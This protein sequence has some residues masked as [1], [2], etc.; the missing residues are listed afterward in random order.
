MTK[1]AHMILRVLFI[2]A[3][4]LLH[5]PD[6]K[7]LKERGATRAILVP[8]HPNTIHKSTLQQLTVVV[9]GAGPEPFPDLSR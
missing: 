2:I 7:K 9:F 3:D 6:V 1:M 8:L 4:Q 5:T